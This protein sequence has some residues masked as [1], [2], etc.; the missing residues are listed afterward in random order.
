MFIYNINVILKV[1]HTLSGLQG[2]QGENVNLS[3]AGLHLRKWTQQA[4]VPGSCYLQIP[5]KPRDRHTVW[6]LQ[7]SHAT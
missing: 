2:V 5:S 7:F 4:A 6:A 1:V 3:C